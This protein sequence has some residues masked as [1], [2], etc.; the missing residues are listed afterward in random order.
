[1]EK[2]RTDRAGLMLRA[3]AAVAL[4]ALGSCE[5]PPPGTMLLRFVNASLDL[6]AIDVY[7]SGGATPLLSNIEFG[8]ASEW[9]EL[10]AVTT[11]FELRFA[12]AAPDSPPVLRAGPFVFSANSQASAIAIGELGTDDPLA[13][14]RV[15]PIVESAAAP[16]PGEIRVR[17]LN[18][19][20]G[21]S[22]ISVRVDDTELVT[23]LQPRSSV[24][25]TLAGVAEIATTWRVELDGL[26]ALRT[27][28]TPPLPDTT[29]V[30]AIVC[31]ALYAGPGADTLTLILVTPDG[32]THPL[33]AE[34]EPA[35][36]ESS[37]A[38]DFH[39]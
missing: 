14:V 24:D 37:T 19:L 28:R 36:A 12:R 35:S 6:G 26:G 30:L 27:F 3:A 10:P 18:A 5:A 34:F 29:R 20:S 7:L 32:R 11:E 23:A 9:V 2:K 1:M 4:L 33:A 13:A 15:I 17:A 25:K 38:G 39:P 8:G 16:A 31:G 21:T 22:T